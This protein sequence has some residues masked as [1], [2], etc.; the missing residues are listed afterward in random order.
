TWSDDNCCLPRGST[1]ATLKGSYPDLVAGDALLFEELLG[2]LTGKPGDADPEHRQVVRLT[3]VLPKQPPPPAPPTTLTDPLTGDLITEIEWAREDRLRFALCISAITD[4]E[5]GSKHLS[6]VSVARGNM[7]LVD[8]GELVSDD[9]GK[10]P[11]AT[12]FEAAG[13]DADRCDPPPR[14]EI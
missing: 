13:C 10:V 9:L 12:L 11:L 14:V 1:K 3:S 4:A 5:H 7:V 6:D 2:P 8:H